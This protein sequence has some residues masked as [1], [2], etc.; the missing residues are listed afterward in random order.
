MEIKI[1]FRLNKRFGVIER[2]V[3]RFVLNGFKDAVEISDAMPIFSDIV[4]ANAIRNLVNS[5]IITASTD[6]SV[7]NLS[8]PIIA[9]I[10]ICQSNHYTVTFSPELEKQI[11]DTGIVF[12]DDRIKETAS[13]KETI[14][15]TILPN[16]KI[17]KFVKQYAKT[18]DFVIRE[19][20]EEE[21]N[22]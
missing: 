7:L 3:F 2:T 1:D 6:S 13:V 18:L 15:Q 10:D 16:V 5:Q 9:I 17:D 19:Y 14:L 4:I 20:R 11:C 22:E 21:Q 8:D 12:S